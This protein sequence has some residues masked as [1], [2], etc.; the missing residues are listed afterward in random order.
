MHQDLTG[1]RPM[2]GAG[3]AMRGFALAIATVDVAAA[4]AIVVSISVMVALVAA[5]VLM[6]YVF[7]ASV[8]WTDE[9]SRL[10][11]VWSIFLGI[12]LGIRSGSHIGIAALTA[13]LPEIPRDTLAGAMALLGAVLMGLV[14]WQSAR[15]AYEQWDELMGA[16][17][18]STGWF[19]LAVAF[20]AAH[21]M[22]H[23]AWIVLNGPHEGFDAV[24]EGGLQ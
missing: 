15:I 23:L 6:R 24:N 22:L 17:N 7:N 14:A 2:A 12:P 9:T 5:Q 21:S 20:G 1:F 13:R 4:W 18:M 11:F 19:M 10:A 16:V 8:S 3:G